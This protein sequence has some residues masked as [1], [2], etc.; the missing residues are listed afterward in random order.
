MPAAFSSA[1]TSASFGGFGNVIGFGSL[2]TRGA[3]EEH[4]LRAERLHEAVARR[5]IPASASCRM[6]RGSA[7]CQRL[8]PDAAPLGR[9]SGTGK[10]GSSAFGAG[11]RV[12][13]RARL[14]APSRGRAGDPRK[15]ATRCGAAPRFRAAHVHAD[16]RNRIPGCAGGA[17]EQQLR[18]QRPGRGPV[19]ISRSA[20]C[21]RSPAS[22]DEITVPFFD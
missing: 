9:T 21:V 18:I 1:P 16:A 4:L 17:A 20:I 7:R 14:Q 5:G 22:R 10:P 19:H 2:P 8:S 13:S 6:S 3:F 11:S 12:P 15:A